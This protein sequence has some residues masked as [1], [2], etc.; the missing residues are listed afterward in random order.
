MKC[1][2]AE[3]LNASQTFQT[4]IINLSQDGRP[5]ATPSWYRASVSRGFV[6]W[7]KV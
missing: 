1:M 6:D 2:D 7:F 4:L 5:T 3:T